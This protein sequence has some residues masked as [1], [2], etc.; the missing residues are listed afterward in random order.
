MLPVSV[1][2]LFIRARDRI[3]FIARMAIEPVPVLELDWG[4]VSA[5]GGTS[6]GV[7]SEVFRQDRRV[8]IDDIV[9]VLVVFPFDKARPES[10]ELNLL[11]DG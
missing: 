4:C 5:E 3:D 2:Q 8:F 11:L 1:A 10:I 7:L 9:P 6:R